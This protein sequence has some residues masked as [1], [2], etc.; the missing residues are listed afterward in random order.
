[1]PLIDRGI[2]RQKVQIFS[3]ILVPDKTTQTL[4]E[5][6]REG[7]VVLSPVSVFQ[8]NSGVHGGFES[9]GSGLRGRFNGK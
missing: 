4:A 3:A 2:G 9:H 8:V 7:V 1:M 6:Y 5:H